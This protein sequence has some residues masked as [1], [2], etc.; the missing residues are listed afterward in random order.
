MD[1]L[2]C[3]PHRLEAIHESGGVYLVGLKD[4]QKEL[5]S[6]CVDVT[7]F[8]K[9]SFS[10][11]QADYNPDTS[12]KPKHGR[13]EKREYQVYDMSKEENHERWSNCKINTL[14]RVKMDIRGYWAV[15]VNNH[16]RDVTFAEDKLTSK[17]SLYHVQWLE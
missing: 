2:H 7:R 11:I 13:I 14:I 9:P 1:A 4:N 8:S 12:I 10:F 6:Q 15:E 3:K 16:I 5:L 17:K